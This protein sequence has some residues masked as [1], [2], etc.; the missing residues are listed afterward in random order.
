[1]LTIPDTEEIQTL[2]RKRAGNYDFTAN[3]YYLIGFRE[4]AYR[5][6]PI[7]ELHL[8]DGETVV[9]MCCGTGLNFALLEQVVGSKGK[10]IGVDLTDA[11]LEQ[12]KKRVKRNGWSNVDLIQS[13]AAMFLFPKGING[14][15]STFAITLVPQ[16][17]AVIEN[18]IEALAPGKRLV[19][20]DLKLPDNWLKIFVPLGVLLTRPFA[21]TRELAERHP[22]ESIR[23]SM[24]KYAFKELYGG[25]A[26][27]ASGEKG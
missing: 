21:V 26:Y 2:Y 27:I 1:M 16:F 24:Q 23:S 13:D 5:K 25:L 19:V 22:W 18:G 14:I 12:A 9:E 15:L 6:Q 8:R 11:M 3:L 10:I 4:W 7:G 17:D 20:L